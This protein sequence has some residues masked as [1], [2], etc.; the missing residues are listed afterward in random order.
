M[1]PPSL[2]STYQRYKQD[3]NIVASWLASTAL[4]CGYA[5]DRLK[6]PA[7]A[8]APAPSSSGRLKGK[9]RKEAKRAKQQQGSQATT[10]RPKH[11]IAVADFVTL[12]EFIA[13]SKSSSASLPDFFI[14]ALSRVISLRSSFRDRMSQEGM[15]ED[16]ASDKTHNYFTK[17]LD[18]VRTTLK[19]L[20][21]TTQTEDLPSL[22]RFEN[23]KLYEPSQAFLDAP[24]PAP[25]KPDKNQPPTSDAS[26]VAEQSST[27]EEVIFAWTVM[28]KDL[29]ALRNYIKAIWLEHRN[30]FFDAAVAALAT[31]TA[32]DLARSIMD[33]VLPLAEQHGGCWLIAQC[34]HRGHCLG[35]GLDPHDDAST[36]GTY[37]TY[38]IASDTLVATYTLLGLLPEYLDER[39]ILSFKEWRYFHYDPAKDRQSLSGKEKA[40]EDKAILLHLVADLITVVRLLPEYPVEDELLR[41]MKELDRTRKVS[42]ALA[43]AAQVPSISTTSCGS[44]PRRRVRTCFRP[45]GFSTTRSP[46]SSTSTSRSS[47]RLGR[48]H[49]T[50]RCWRCNS[51]CAGF[52]RIPSTTSRSRPSRKWVGP[53]PQI[54]R[55]TSCWPFRP[56]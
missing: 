28:T 10:K 43:F 39:P 53:T 49:A 4:A 50:R 36:T 51:R 42:F 3:T 13:S 29:T 9:D 20:M 21:P 16:A 7:A 30:G 14:G 22:N 33:E 41:G 1:L 56:S 52:V 32:V 48:K 26:Y 27:L 12:A 8:A 38:D 6:N 47:P 46:P 18:Q 15:A 34:F 17:I 40:C 55:S 35:R 31:N 2:S 19:P 23:L 37:G 25:S 45:R 54:R 11:I 5:P 24:A 44:T